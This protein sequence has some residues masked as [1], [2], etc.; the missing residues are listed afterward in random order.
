MGKYISKVPVTFIPGRKHTPPKSI[1]KTPGLPR[2]AVSREALMVI[3]IT[4]PGPH[5]IGWFCK[6]LAKYLVLPEAVITLLMKG[7]TKL[8]LSYTVLYNHTQHDLQNLSEM[9][10]LFNHET[11]KLPYGQYEYRLPRHR[12]AGDDTYFT[13]EERMKAKEK[14]SFL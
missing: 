9:G 14:D 6:Q 3:A 7:K 12:K 11:G 2:K 10:H 5:S 8:R 1:R 4:N 13:P